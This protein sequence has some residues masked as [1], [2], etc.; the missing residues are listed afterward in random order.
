MSDVHLIPTFY[1]HT[2]MHDKMSFLGTFNGRTTK[3]GKIW[4]R[5]CSNLVRTPCL[6][7]LNRMLRAPAHSWPKTLP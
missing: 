5:T 6:D 1:T 4:L 2:G 7:H 3:G